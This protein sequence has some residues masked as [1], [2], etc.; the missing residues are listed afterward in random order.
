MRRVIFLQMKQNLPYQEMEHMR[1]VID[2]LPTDI[3]ESYYFLLIPEQISVKGVE[4][5]SIEIKE[6][7]K[8]ILEVD[9]ILNNNKFRDIIKI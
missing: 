8:D 7:L 9:E 4:D 3:K 6:S 2:D 5:L 1:K